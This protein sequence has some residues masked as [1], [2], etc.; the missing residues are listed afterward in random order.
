LRVLPLGPLK[1]FNSLFNNWYCYQSLV[2]PKQLPRHIHTI[3]IHLQ[4]KILLSRAVQSRPPY[5]L[6]TGNSPSHVLPFVDKTE[7]HHPKIELS[8]LFPLAALSHSA[9]V[10]KSSTF[11]HLRN[12]AKASFHRPLAQQGRLSLPFYGTTRYPF[13]L[14]PV[15]PNRSVP[16]L[17]E[18]S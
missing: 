3:Q 8:D 14:L 4:D 17:L 10:G 11:A 12:I 2:L 1:R 15:S 5:C 6:F 18:K 7:S 13:R 9:S 16:P